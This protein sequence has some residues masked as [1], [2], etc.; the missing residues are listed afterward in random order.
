MVQLAGMCNA[1]L[2]PRVTAFSAGGAVKRYADAARLMGLCDEGAAD[3]DAAPGNSD[4]LQR[5]R[6][7]MRLDSLNGGRR[8][9]SPTRCR[10]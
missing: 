3:I 5:G 1:M 2:L 9:T 6:A 7:V 10:R 8:W 4:A